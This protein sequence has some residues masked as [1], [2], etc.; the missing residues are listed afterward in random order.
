MFY[1]KSSAECTM[2]NLGLVKLGVGHFCRVLGSIILESSQVFKSMLG[3][4]LK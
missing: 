2:L 3:S 1:V 4:T